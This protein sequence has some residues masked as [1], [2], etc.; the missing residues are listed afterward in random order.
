MPPKKS[1]TTNQKPSPSSSPSQTLPTPTAPTTQTTNQTQSSTNNKTAPDKFSN[2]SQEE[3]ENRSWIYAANDL[4]NDNKFHSDDLIAGSIIYGYKNNVEKLYEDPLWIRMMDHHGKGLLYEMILKNVKY[5]M[6]IVQVAI[7]RLY[8]LDCLVCHSLVHC[9]VD[10]TNHIV[11]NLWGDFG[12]S[13]EFLHSHGNGVSAHY[14]PNI[15]K[16]VT[17]FHDGIYKHIAGGPNKRRAAITP[18]NECRRFAN[19]ARQRIEDTYMLIKWKARVAEDTGSKAMTNDDYEQINE[20]VL[21]IEQEKQNEAAKNPK[22]PPKEN[23]TDK[24]LR[25]Q[26][27]DN[28]ILMVN[29]T[30]MQEVDQHQLVMG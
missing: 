20:A 23:A 4:E 29:P 25:G 13:F 17:E 26:K 1:P 6:A 2:C 15:E 8:Q 9:G 11:Q 24:I 10:F 27:I 12:T 14:A 22:K 21:R 19:A 16:A 5:W 28:E 18:N 3:I 7:S 30:N